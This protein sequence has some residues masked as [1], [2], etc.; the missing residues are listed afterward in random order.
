MEGIGKGIGD[1]IHWGVRVII[2]L[3]ALSVLLAGY[4]GYTFLF[5][6]KPDWQQEAVKDGV[7]QFYYDSETGERKFK[8][9]ATQ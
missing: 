2:V 5:P 9:L 7:G 8:W 1:L 3:A 6:E 4:I